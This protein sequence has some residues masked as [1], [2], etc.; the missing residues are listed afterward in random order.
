MVVRYIQNILLKGG[1]HMMKNIGMK[2]GVAV[3]ALAITAA[4]ATAVMAAKPSGETKPGW[5][6]GDKN[7]VH[8]GPPGQS[9]RTSK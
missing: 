4:T 7:H 3:V 2:A 6:Y 5:G 8:T 9:V 1:C